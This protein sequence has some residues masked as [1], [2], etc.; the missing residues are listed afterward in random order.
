MRYF[1]PL[2]K[3]P[4][5]WHTIGG[6]LPPK[7]QAPN[8][9]GEVRA[10]IHIPSFRLR[11]IR[12]IF[13][14]EGETFMQ[15]ATKPVTLGLIVGNRGFF[16]AHLCDTGRTTILKV[17]EKEG[18]NVVALTPEESHLRLHREPRR[19][20]QVRRPLPRPPQRDR[21][22]AGHAAQLRRRARHRQCPALGRA[23]RAG[24]HPRLP[25]RPG[26]DDRQGPP[27]FLLRQDV[28]LQQPAPVWDQVLHHPPPHRGPRERQLPR[29][30][31]TLRRHLS[32]RARAEVR[33]H[34]RHRRPPAGLQHRALQRETAG[35]LR[36]HR[37]DAGSLRDLRA[38]REAGRRRQRRE[39]QAGPD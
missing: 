16:P 17:L 9:G 36:H 14:I 30:S 23:G 26:Q 12:I 39:G 37:G 22:R 13:S 32:R 20:P 28:H 29:G 33:P 11:P 35:T 34:R 8:A 6:K 31:A 2:H 10:A 3:T 15:L 21:R 38:H 24:A 19:S 7:P 5:F 27:R 4:K 25:R 1:H 18:F